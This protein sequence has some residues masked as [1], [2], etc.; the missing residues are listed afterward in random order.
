[1]QNTAV[2]KDA[3]F[4]CYATMKTETDS[5]TERQRDRETTQRGQRGYREY[6]ADV[7][8]THFELMQQVNI[9]TV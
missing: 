7:V 5:E 3:Q 8:V 6:R 2:N 1:M 9:Q 4:N